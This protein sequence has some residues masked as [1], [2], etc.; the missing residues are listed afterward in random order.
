[1]SITELPPID[2]TFGDVLSKIRRDAGLT[3]A[4]LAELLDVSERTIGNYE[5]DNTLPK[6]GLV[7]QWANVCGY[8]YV[9]DLLHAWGAARESGWI[10]GADP[11]QPAL[12][13]RDDRGRLIPAVDLDNAA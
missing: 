12:F 5:R 4:Q 1:M 2:W 6:R 8:E 13:V 10:Y 11:P 3:G 9:D 7:A